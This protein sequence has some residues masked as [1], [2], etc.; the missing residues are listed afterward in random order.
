MAAQPDL[1]SLLEE[2]INRLLAELDS[3]RR[4]LARVNDSL[5]AK[6]KLCHSQEQ[7][8]RTAQKAKAETQ[9]LH[10]LLAES[11]KDSHLQRDA[12]HQVEKQLQGIVFKIDDYLK[13]NTI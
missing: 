2:R 12:G 9:L 6:E 11:V 7:L 3:K 13:G 1:F 4:E 5:A 8:L 10:K